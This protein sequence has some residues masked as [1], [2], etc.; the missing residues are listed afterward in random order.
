MEPMRRHEIHRSRGSWRWRDGRSVAKNSTDGLLGGIMDH[1]GISI[2]EVACCAPCCQK[3]LL[4]KQ[5]CLNHAISTYPIVKGEEKLVVFGYG[6]ERL[7]TRERAKA[8]ARKITC[9]LLTPM[10]VFYSYS[11]I[12]GFARP[13]GRVKLLTDSHHHSSSTM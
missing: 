9:E 12:E 6:R 10:L 4:K 1:D 13:N 8:L 3:V 7:Y 5:H 2:G 11:C